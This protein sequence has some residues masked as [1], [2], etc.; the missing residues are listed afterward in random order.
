MNSFTP[1]MEPER[2]KRLKMKAALPLHLTVQRTNERLGMTVLNVTCPD[3]KR[4]DHLA[5]RSDGMEKWLLQTL[6]QLAFPE[7]TPFQ[8]EQLITGYC[9]ACWNRMW[10]LG[11]EEAGA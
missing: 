4:E 2:L 5:V 1:W 7:L 6:V 11:E 8:R 10:N 3:C 9:L